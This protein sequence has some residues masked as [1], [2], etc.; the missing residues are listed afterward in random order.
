MAKSKRFKR[1]KQFK[2][3]K[4][5]KELVPAS[6]AEKAAELN[7]L[8]TAPVQPSLKNVPQI[9]SESI[10]E[11]REEVLKG[12]R[13]YIYPLQHSKRKIVAITITV[14]IAAIIGL[15]VY[16]YFALYRYYQYNTFVYRVT[17]VVP[18]PVAKTGGKYVDY[19]NYLFE[20]RHRVHY[21]ESQQQS[22]VAANPDQLGLFRKQSLQA[23]IDNAYVVQLAS[24]HH[25]GVSDKEVDARMTEVRNQNRL[26][27]NNKVFSDVLRDYWGWSINDFRRSLK[28]EILA[29]KVSAAL[30]NTDSQK[31]TAVLAQAKNGADFTAL[32]KQS[33]DDPATKDTGGDYGFAI[34]KTNPNV[35]PEV[36]DQL[37]K[38]QAGQVSDLILASPV[39]AGQPPSL[40]IV[41]VTGINGDAVT[42]QHIVINLK[43]AETY[44][45]QLQSKK[46]AHSYVKF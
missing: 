20:L 26:G 3:T 28:Q 1:I 35:P 21:Y 40:Q 24:S 33:S 43:N 29:E 25:I 2:K 22:N 14:I 45:K 11:H 42:A 15:F 12:A 31:A 7:P 17:Q 6:I 5:V 41:K 9:T 18:F 34:T 16:C 32:A 30:D 27:G 19:E 37:F 44:I 39:I 8:P 10:A 23:V 13:K 4:D 36:V 46:P 38:L